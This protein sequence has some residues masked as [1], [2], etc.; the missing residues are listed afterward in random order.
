M[1]DDGFFRILL[2]DDD[3]GMARQIRALLASGG[4]TLWRHVSTV[5]EALHEALDAD[6]VL[7]DHQLPDGTGL[8]VLEQLRAIAPDGPGVIL[9]TAHGNEAVAAAALRLG[10]DDYLRK[11]EALPLLLPQVVE[12]VRRLRAMRAALGAADRDHEAAS[13]LGVIAE[14]SATLRH[15]LSNPLMAALVEVDLMLGSGPR[16]PGDTREGLEAVRVS[17][18]RIREVLRRM[19]GLQQVATLERPVEVLLE[20]PGGR[21][22]RPGVAV[23]LVDDQDLAQLAA[24]LL[25]HAGFAVERQR[26]AA[27]LRERLTLVAPRVIVADAAHAAEAHAVLGDGPQAGRRWRLLLLAEP[28][29][30]LSDVAAADRVVPLPIDPAAFGQHVLAALR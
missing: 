20:R 3:P 21:L 17:L 26:T 27:V 16:L 24:R 23:V 30:A 15:E 14:Q 29:A 6:L 9:I 18:G 1:A 8:G 4:F 7:L 2:V 19:E 10:A 28:D 13:R 11:D 12:R 25:H 22:E 5:A